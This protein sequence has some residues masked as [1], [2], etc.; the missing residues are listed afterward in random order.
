MI[1]IL[2]HPEPHPKQGPEIVPHEMHHLLESQKKL[3][4]LPQLQDL[5]ADQAFVC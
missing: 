1:T 5:Q 3:R 4:E 2:L